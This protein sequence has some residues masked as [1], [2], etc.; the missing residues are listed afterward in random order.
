MKKKKIVKPRVNKK[1]L[2]Q[3]RLN[4]FI[5][6]SLPTS[7]FIFIAGVFCYVAKPESLILMKS[8]GVALIAM[9]IL[10]FVYR[11]IAFK[12]YIKTNGTVNI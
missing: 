6:N 4:V 7:V 8:F 1:K 10:F 9:S 11:F 5:N 3:W 2:K 12:L